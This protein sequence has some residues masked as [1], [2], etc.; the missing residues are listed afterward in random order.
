MTSGCVLT[1]VDG[2]LRNARHLQP[3]GLI[4]FLARMTVTQF[5]FALFALLIVGLMLP[6][7]YGVRMGLFLALIA[8]GIMTFIGGGMHYILSPFR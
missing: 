2:S 3:L 5:L 4:L 6:L 7:P 1:F 8:L